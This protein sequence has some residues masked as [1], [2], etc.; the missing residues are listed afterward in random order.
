MVVRIF[1]LRSIGMIPILF[2]P[3][4]VLYSRRFFYRIYDKLLSIVWHDT[5][6]SNVPCF[7]EWSPHKIRFCF[8][9]NCPIWC[10][11][12]VMLLNGLCVCHLKL[13]HWCHYY[14][15][16]LVQMHPEKYSMVWWHQDD[17]WTGQSS[18]SLCLC[19]QLPHLQKMNNDPFCLTWLLAVMNLLSGA[20]SFFTT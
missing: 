1:I 12:T 9:T 15:Q 7:L 19:Q 8:E 11:T 17:Y 5:S 13:L 14:P 4:E 18:P 6:V 10:K 2:Y 16:Q 20:L 3:V